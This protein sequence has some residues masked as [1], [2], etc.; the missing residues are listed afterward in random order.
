VLDTEQTPPLEGAMPLNNPR[1]VI[2]RVALGDPLGEAM[3]RFRKWLD[4]EKSN[5]PLSGWQL[6]PMATGRHAAERGRDRG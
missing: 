5:P 3:G 1:T 4:R 2:V 6:M